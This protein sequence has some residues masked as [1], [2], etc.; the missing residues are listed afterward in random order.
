M[1]TSLFQYEMLPTTWFYLSALM[2][3]A[4]FFRFNRFWSIRN[5]DIIGLIA[6]TP[7]LLF[8]AMGDDYSGYVWL[9]VL[10]LFMFLRL[11]FDLFMVRRPL[12]EPNLASSG[13]IFSSIMLVMFLIPNLLINRGEAIDSYRTLRLEQILTIKNDYERDKGRSVPITDRPG[14]LPFRKLTDRVNQIF[15]PPVK[16]REEIFSNGV[17]QTISLSRPAAV[18]TIDSLPISSSEKAI[19]HYRWHEQNENEAFLEGPIAV[20]FASLAVPSEAKN[21]VAD[22]DILLDEPKDTPE[23][24]VPSAPTGAPDV[25]SVNLLLEQEENNRLLSDNGTPFLD[26]VF[27][28]IFVIL[29]QFATVFGMIAIGHCHFG[30]L[31]TG[32][33]AAMVY[34][35]L[36]YVN[37]MPGSLDHVIPGMLL[38]LAA[39]I[40]RR[41][42][43]S[44]F[45]IGLAGCLVFY[46]FFLLP[47]W[48]S[49]YWKRGAH[50]FLIG[51]V[52]AVLMMGL[53]L[54]GSPTTLGSYAKQIASMFGLHSI[55]ISHPIGLWAFLPTYYRIPIIALYMVVVFGLTLW[56]TRKNFATLIGCTA[57]LMLGAQFWMGHYGGL[58]MGWYLPLL[59]LT[60]FRP[61]LEDRVATATVIEV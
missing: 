7:G 54:L 11:L 27:L 16:V 12:L 14:Y 13:L 9:H 25:Q 24:A 50:R 56:P 37:Q 18:Q 26:E 48:I 15:M 46:P 40:Y 53:I 4:T 59:I 17:F 22:P 1:P 58:Y 36:P 45:L 8:L 3:I 39:A 52:S 19:L 29:A 35:L 49:F 43:F 47:L 20:K 60:L 6:F 21:T 41:P 5:L 30:N 61:N 55:L 42:I 10:G 32:V 23:A 33:A 44:G 38:V 31:K 34:L 57:M 2:I 51:V 28:V